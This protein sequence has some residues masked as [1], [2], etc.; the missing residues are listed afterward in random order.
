MPDQEQKEMQWI[1]KDIE[2]K[3]L[4]LYAVGYIKNGNFVAVAYCYDHLD[5]EFIWE[6]F[7]AQ[8]TPEGLEMWKGH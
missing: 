6:A 8:G 7:T 5:K 4:P 3:G 2:A 1:I